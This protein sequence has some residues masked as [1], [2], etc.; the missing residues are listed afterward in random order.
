MNIKWIKVSDK[1]IEPE[2]IDDIREAKRNGDDIPNP[3]YKR[4]INL[5]EE[6][7]KLWA[8]ECFRVLKPGGYLLS[9]S[10]TRTYHRMVV[11]LENIGFDIQNMIAWCYGSGFPKATDVSKSIDKKKLREELTEK[12]GHK[13]TS[14]QFKQAWQ[15]EREKIGEGRGTSLNKQNEIN[16]EHGFRPDDYY[17]DDDGTFDRTAPST[18]E[19]EKWDGWKCGKSSLKPALEPIVVAQKPISEDSYIENILKWGVGCMNIDD[20]RISL[21]GEEPPSGSA[22][23]VFASNEYTEEKRYGDN[24]ETPEDGRYPA[25]II[26]DPKSAEL[27]DEQSG[28]LHKAGNVRESNINDYEASSYK[29]GIGKRNPNYHN[30]ERGASRFFYSAKAHKSERN[31]GLDDLK[32]RDGFTENTNKTRNRD[33]YSMAHFC[34][35]CGKRKDSCTCSNPDYEIKEQPGRKKDV[36]NDISTLKPISLMRYLCRLVTPPDGTVLDPFMGSG[37]TGCACMIEGFDFIGIEK[38]ERFAELIAPHRIE[39]WANPNNWNELKEHKELESG[40]KLKNEEKNAGLDKF[41]FGDE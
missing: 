5:Y 13:P 11:G 16:K 40:E 6:F 20:C 31:A 2:N 12:L 23:R 27:L 33:M 26:L 8:K 7:C 35:K 37:T 25:N 32:D 14:S 29:A 17:E 21:N 22:K 18:P 24:K 4:K 28:E 41:G 10:G 3:V 34:K 39:Y 1:F 38:R 15:Y 30:D 19:A 9:F 36:K